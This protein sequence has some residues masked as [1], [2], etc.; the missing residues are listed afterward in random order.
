MTS[1]QLPRLGRKSESKEPAGSGNLWHWGWP[2]LGKGIVEG[3]AL[4]HPGG[5]MPPFLPGSTLLE[6]SHW[7]LRA[8]LLVSAMTSVP[9]SSPS[10]I[11]AISSSVPTIYLEGCLLPLLLLSMKLPEPERMAHF[12]IPSALCIEWETFYYMSKLHP[13]IWAMLKGG[14]LTHVTFEPFW[15]T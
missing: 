12:K 4:F 7:V 13:K 2:L 1:S 3:K 6:T 8:S 11:S 10:H 14:L 9:Y 15:Q 5:N